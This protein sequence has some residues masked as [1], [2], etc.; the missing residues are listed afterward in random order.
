MMRETKCVVVL[1]L[2]FACQL[3][4]QG[5]MAE[6]KSVA[7]KKL[8]EVSSEVADQKAKGGK[9][10][11][12][13]CAKQAWV[14]I[15]GDEKIDAPLAGAVTVMVAVRGENFVGLSE[16]LRISAN[17]ISNATSEHYSGY[18]FIQGTRV[19]PDRY[20]ELPLTV[21]LPAKPDQYRFNVGLLVTGVNPGK[22]IPTAF[23]A[24]IKVSAHDMSN[25]YIS[26]VEPDKNCYRP[27]EKI[28]IVVSV[29]NPTA[30]AF[31]GE[32]RLKELV[33]IADVAEEESA[34]A[35]VPATS[36]KEIVVTWKAGRAEA[37]R[38]LRVELLDKDGKALDSAKDHYGVAKDPSYLSTIAKNS[39]EWAGYAPGVYVFYV[40]P[41]SF[42]QTLR[43]IN[44]CKFRRIQRMEYFSWSYNELAQFIPPAGEE[45]YLGNEGMW[46]QSLKKF[47]EQIG[48]LKNIG[49][50][51]ITYV[52][53]HLWGPAAYKL[54]Q[55]H[56]EWFM[57]TKSGELSSGG[58]YDMEWRSL[59]GRRGE[60]E[61]QQ[62]KSPF[63]YANLNPVLPE[64]RKYIADQFIR[65]AKEMGFEGAR[66]D[67][68]SMEV[69]RGNYDFYGNEIVKT[70]EE[71]DRLSAE[72]LKA[73]KDLVAEEVPSFS[74]GYN[75][76]SPE[77]NATTPLLLA[78]KCRGGGWLLDEVV[79]NYQGKTSPFHIWSAYAP[80]MVGW[81]DKIRQLGGLYNPYGFRREGGKY[82]ID[83]L[84]EGI[85]RIIAGGRMDMA[86]GF[87]SNLSGK[88]G[89]TDLLPFRFSDSFLSWNLRLQ[90]ESQNVVK[91]EAP[92]TLW[93][94]NMV[95]ENKCAKGSAQRIVHLVNSPL[96][97]EA[98]ENPSS[99]V[100]DPVP[101]VK[102]VCGK[103][104]GKLPA[105][106]WLL[107]AEPVTPTEEP[108]VKAVPL[109]LE[110]AG[111]AVSVVVPSVQ[112][113]KTVVFEF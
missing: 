84:Y 103:I 15:S 34:A 22:E 89:E 112:F 111:D 54:F 109:K 90:P 95:F 49:V 44:F 98:E 76:A 113:F 56:P 62:K 106:A 53:G 80:R 73:V 81:G 92:E 25:A 16:P 79:C 101:N 12:V 50:T 86:G 19:V 66:W 47:K 11:S 96:A 9:A 110:P 38:E 24:D 99:A 58:G 6:V 52:N 48:M 46:W 32:L 31:E 10:I 30:Q 102:V 5:G 82:P 70:E 2:A 105:K 26:R 107:T 41:A 72:S 14:T 104:D 18:G 64:S 88:V 77:E 45:P 13:P 33:D 8:S 21:R 91:V 85:F 42:S 94:K 28:K 100:R 39:T 69:K 71:S 51:P 27:G 93:W 17:F 35:E 57:Y 65:V 97:S 36:I 4:V 67:V 37:G 78:E 60:F 3:A 40:G 59:Y 83:R 74:W 55:E 108:E 43:G 87:I 61:F 68:W 75:Y 23:F 1:V 29:V 63:F 20:V 7:V